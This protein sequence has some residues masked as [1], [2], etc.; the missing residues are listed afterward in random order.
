MPSVENHVRFCVKEF[1]EENRKLCYMVNSWM[2]APSRE[3]GGKHRIVRHDLLHTW[4]TLLMEHRCY[5]NKMSFEDI[6]RLRE[7]FMSIDNNNL[8]KYF[9]RSQ[10]ILEMIIQHL[11]LDG[12]LTPRQIEELHNEPLKVK[13]VYGRD[14]GEMLLFVL[15]LDKRKTMPIWRRIARGFGKNHEATEELELSSMP[16]LTF[17]ELGRLM[18]YKGYLTQEEL[19]KFSTD[20]HKKPE[21]LSKAIRTTDDL[22]KSLLDRGRITQD[23][24]KRLIA[25]KSDYDKSIDLSMEPTARKRYGELIFL[26]CLLDVGLI[27]QDWHK[28]LAEAT[29]SE[30]L[31]DEERI[32]QEQCKEL[33]ELGFTSDD[34]LKAL[35]IKGN[36]AQKDYEGFKNL[37]LMDYDFFKYLLDSGAVTQEG[38]K[39]LI[40]LAKSRGITQ[41][42]S[43]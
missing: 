31:S 42:E 40:E 20:F 10:L 18:Y 11:E 30:A 1:G 22:L 33:I 23:E 19:G 16:V 41:E 12:I 2:D 14:T 7:G 4:Q 36:I 39:D 24:Y 21:P 35:L 5:E 34:L 8:G 38:F 6:K 29:R 26:K 17:E 13:V 37:G 25:S 32:A 27:T 43:K 3:L 15:P 9:P 28:E